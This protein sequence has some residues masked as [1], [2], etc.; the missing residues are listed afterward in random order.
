[1]GSNYA[2]ELRKKQLRTTANTSSFRERQASAN[3][4]ESPLLS[5]EQ[6]SQATIANNLSSALGQS[7]NGKQSSSRSHRTNQFLSTSTKYGSSCLQRRNGSHVGRRR[8]VNL[9]HNQGYDTATGFYQ[10]IQGDHLDYRYETLKEIGRGTFGQ[11]LLCMDHK[12][13]KHVAIKVSKNLV[14][15]GVDNCMREV[16]LLDQAN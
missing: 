14:Q 6:N 7:I 3:R 1:M 16:R 10:A 8:N 15:A 13:G 9:M 12:T 11:V 2:K 4:G 5:S